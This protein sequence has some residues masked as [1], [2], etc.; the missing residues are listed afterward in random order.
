MFRTHAAFGFFLALLFL[1]FFPQP[2]PFLFL[3]LVALCSALPDID[4]PK[5]KLGRKF[6]FISIPLS[7]IVRHRG[8]THSIFPVLGIFFLFKY[9]NL[10]YLALAVSLGYIAHL[11]GDGISKEGINILHPLA[12][13]HISGFFKVGGPTEYIIFI[14]LCILDFF[15]F[16]QF[17]LFF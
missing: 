2:Y 15:F 13:L 16:F 8:I 17:F 9:L 11:L 3:I 1:K 5:S 10:S 12:K 7:L 14:A 6:S 4:T